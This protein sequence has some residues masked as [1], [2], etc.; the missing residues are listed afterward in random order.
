MQNF[1]R[2]SPAAKRAQRI[3]QAKVLGFRAVKWIFPMAFAASVQCLHAYAAPAPAPECKAPAKLNAHY[4][5]SQIAKSLTAIQAEVVAADPEPPPTVSA[6]DQKVTFRVLHTWKG[7]HHAGET[8]SLTLHVVNLCAG[9]GCVFPFKPR[10]VTLVLFSVS[11]SNLPE[12][13]GCWRHDGLEF[14]DI[15]W[16]PI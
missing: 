9:F 6:F 14:H 11:A 16:A 7:P 13:A 2:F 12:G 15:L 5:E 3:Q 10:D 4:I 1:H 8:I